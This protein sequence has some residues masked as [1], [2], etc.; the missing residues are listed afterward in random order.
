[1]SRE[2]HFRRNSSEFRTHLRHFRL[3]VQQNHPYLVRR[4]GLCT[5]QRPSFHQQHHHSPPSA[6][7]ACHTVEGNIARRICTRLPVPVNSA[8]IELDASSPSPLETRQPHLRRA[9]LLQ[10]QLTETLAAV[11]IPSTDASHLATQFVLANESAQFP[12]ASIAV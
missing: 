12:L 4:G 2:T 5:P 1:M 3:H 11:S 9:L 10:T 8:D 7:L 6:P